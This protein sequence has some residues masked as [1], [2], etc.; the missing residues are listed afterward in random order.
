M[1]SA[2]AVFKIGVIPFKAVSRTLRM[3]SVP[4]LSR[5]RRSSFLSKNAFFIE[6]WRTVTPAARIGKKEFLVV[7]A[8]ND[9]VVA[10]D[11][12]LDQLVHPDPQKEYLAYKMNPDARKSVGDFVRA[13]K[14]TVLTKEEKRQLFK[15]VGDYRRKAFHVLQEFYADTPRLDKIIRM[16]EETSGEWG[17]AAVK[18]L[19][20]LGQVPR[21]NRRSV[22]EAFANS[23]MATQIADDLF[24]LVEDTSR[25]TP[26]IAVGIFMGHPDELRNALSMEKPSMHLF[27]KLCPK[28]IAKIMD[29]YRGYLGKIPLSDNLQIIRI[30]PRLFINFLSLT[31]R[32]QRLA[33]Q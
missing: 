20:I 28:S 11:D 22:E 25:K 27:K 23:F 6:L 2:K 24:D 3:R 13:V 29:L 14:G 8:F 21:E 19:D 12:I 15:V 16:K 4:R 17:C 33:P 7:E 9:Y 26:S 5:R 10:I 30:F 31:K 18:L 1:F 32:R